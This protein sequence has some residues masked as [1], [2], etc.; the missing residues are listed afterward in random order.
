MTNIISTELSHNNTDFFSRVHFIMV[1]P[2][3]PGNVG[4][5]ARAIKTMGFH[6]LHLVAPHNPD[7]LQ[8]PDAHALASGA[9]DVLMQTK[10][11]TDLAAAL[12]NTSLAFGLTARPRALGAPPCDIRQA[13]SQ[14]QHKL[15]DSNAQ[16]AFVLGTERYG[17]SNDE[18]NLC[19]QTCHIPANAEYSSLNVSQALQLAAWEM[20]Y[21]LIQASGLDYMPDTHGRHDPGA[22][23]ASNANIHAMLDHLQQAMIAINFLDPQHPKKLLP[24]IQNMFNRNNL[25]NDEVAILR[26]LSAAM[27]TTAKHSKD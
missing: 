2:S 9:Q 8:H 10:I 15:Y 19:Q 20:R 1:S 16:I 22:D 13:A 12:A 27:I 18:L 4:S 5:A 11:H 3:H 6:N 14:S 25:S 21:A 23:P 17:L 26:G 7:I 24:R